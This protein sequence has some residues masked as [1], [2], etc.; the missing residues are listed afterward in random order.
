MHV[1]VLSKTF[2]AAPAQKLLEWLARQPGLRVTLLTPPAWRTDDGGVQT[3]EP[4]FTTGYRVITLSVARNGRYHTYAY[5]GLRATLDGLRPDMLHCDEEP[6]NLA[7][8]QAVRVAASLSIPAVVVTWQNLL[9]RYP[10]PFAWMEQWVYRH[11]AAIIAGNAGAAEVARAKGYRGPLHTFTLHGIDPACWPPRAPEP[12][13]PDEPFSVGYIGRLVPE[14][15]I[16][17]LLA[18][19]ARLPERIHLCIA[20]RGPLAE[21][22]RHQAASLGIAERVA[23][24]D[25]IPAQDIPTLM[26]R[27]D[28]LALPSRTRPNWTEQFGR[29]LAEAM[30]SGVP[31][32]GSATGEIPHVIGDA[33]LTFPKGDIPALAHCISSLAE[34]PARWR[35][36]AQRGRARAL[37][38]FTHADIAARLVNVYESL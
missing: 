38:H 9:R 24:H 19:L 22:L 20:G 33:G 2:V 34:D 4:I 1:V 13:A 11:A 26:R 10:P 14:K 29:V 7:T 6:Y 37:A 15:G 8:F 23:W 3:F 18:A 36:L 17:D 27:L 31:V 25:H 16:D 5:R 12:P 35:D 30:A 28:A 32:I 21:D